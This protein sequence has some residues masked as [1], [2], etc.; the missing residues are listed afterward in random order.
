MN[1]IFQLSCDNDGVWHLFLL[2]MI[3]DYKYF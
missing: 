1:A 2:I 3:V